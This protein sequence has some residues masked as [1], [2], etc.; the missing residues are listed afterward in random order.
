MAP[1]AQGRPVALSPGHLLF[2]RP[3]GSGSNSKS[4]NAQ[5]NQQS[6]GQQQEI[7]RYK[8]GGRQIHQSKNAGPATQ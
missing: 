4:S 6:G 2:A 7:V 3:K 8:K 5:H 1:T